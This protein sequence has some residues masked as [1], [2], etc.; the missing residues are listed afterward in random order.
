MRGSRWAVA[1]V[2]G[3]ALLLSGC[4]NP[5]DVDGDLADDWIAL[6]EPESFTPP[7]E[8]CHEGSYRP[9]VSLAAFEPV[10][11]AAPHRAETVHVGTFD[12][13]A[14]GR[15]APPA[16][17]SAHVRAAY[18]ECDERARQ[19][20]GDDFRLGRLWLGVVVP[21]ASGWK[22]GAR[23]Y[24]CDIFQIADVEEFGDPV[25]RRG[26][27]KGALAGNAADPAL[28]LGCYAVKARSTG[29]IDTMTPTA[30]TKKHN[31]EFVGVYRASATAGYPASDAA[32]QR[33]HVGCRKEVA[34]YV[35]VPDDAELEFRTGTVVVP[36]LQT[37]WDA[38]NHGVRCYLYLKDASFA[39][40]LRG[41]GAKALP[42]N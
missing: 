40:S 20:L 17:T 41:A 19:Y 25:E 3:A 29:A 2:C 23:W 33:I 12:G 13:A 35:K 24:R 1:A 42:V 9:S 30:C 7:A 32:W 6:A 8:V 31:S 14:A 22:G 10:D 38:G 27:L 37:D 5:G 26:T 21:T 15:P 16:K 4:G 34:R 36:N 28:R 39:R 11:C 18:A